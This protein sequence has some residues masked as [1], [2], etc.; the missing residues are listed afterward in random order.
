MTYESF[1]ISSEQQYLNTG[2][3]Q[4]YG[5]TW[6]LNGKTLTILVNANRKS[7]NWRGMRFEPLEV[8]IIEEAL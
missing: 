6:K 1:L 2:V 4:L 8:K 3:P 7:V 5:R